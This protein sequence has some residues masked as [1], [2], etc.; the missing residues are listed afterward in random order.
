[1]LWIPSPSYFYY[2]FKSLFNGDTIDV[3]I[4]ISSQMPDL[5]LVITRYVILDRQFT[6]KC[7]PFTSGR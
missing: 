5:A 1:M 6:L 7:F 3:D 4:A 2:T